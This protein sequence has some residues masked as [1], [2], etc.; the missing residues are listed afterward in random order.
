MKKVRI[1]LGIVFILAFTVP[2]FAGIMDWYPQNLLSPQVLEQNRIL[3]A[4][5]CKGVPQ[6]VTN[7]YF[8]TY[9][10]GESAYSICY[11]N[12][13]DTR[14]ESGS[15]SIG[16]TGDVSGDGGFAVDV[17]NEVNGV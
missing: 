6:P 9:N 2:S 15:T 10:T 8:Y 4:Y 12:Q 11:G 5:E 3:A 13:N 14:F 7:N 1:A 16:I 17:N